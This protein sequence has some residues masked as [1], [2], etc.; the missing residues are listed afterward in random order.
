MMFDNQINICEDILTSHEIIDMD[1]AA[2]TIT[3]G[4]I[5]RKENG[6]LFVTVPA[7]TKEQ[8]AKFDIL[9]EDAFSNS[10]TDYADAVAKYIN[11]YKKIFPAHLED[12]VTRACNYM[13][14][15]LYATTICQMAKKRGLLKA[16]AADSVCDV[17]IQFK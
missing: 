1:S 16:P 15:T 13:F 12:D 6:E 11:G 17:M 8:K 7:F 9:A 5:V 10:I 4:F 14:L 2:S 3:K